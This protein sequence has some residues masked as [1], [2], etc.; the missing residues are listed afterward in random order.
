MNRFGVLAAALVAAASLGACA[1]SDNN[2]SKAEDATAPASAEPTS[3][4]PTP[5]ELPDVVM[6]DPSGTF[7]H[8]CDYVLGDFTSHT[9]TGYRFVADAQLH[10][11]G[12]IGTVNKVD[13]VWFLSG[14][15]KVNM[16]KTVKVQPGRRA[17]VGFTKPVGSDEIDL[18]QSLSGRRC[19]VKVAMIDTFGDVVE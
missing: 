10:N 5:T 8:S 11:D 9:S 2:D 15:R 7:T 3:P 16:S 12:N 14:G 19:N 13:A 6:P 4:T 18:H 17:R 1:S